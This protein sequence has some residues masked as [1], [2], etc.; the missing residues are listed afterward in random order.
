M[1]MKMVKYPKQSTLEQEFC[2]HFSLQLISALWEKLTS[3]KIAELC[4]D[5]LSVGFYKSRIC[6][7]IMEQFHCQFN[8]GYKNFKGLRQ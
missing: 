4:T 8:L 5:M 3:M 7:M 2:V 1:D 6:D